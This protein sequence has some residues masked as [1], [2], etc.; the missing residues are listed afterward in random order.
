M[1]REELRRGSSERRALR[2]LVKSLTPGPRTH[3]HAKSNFLSVII[4]DM[5]QEYPNFYTDI[6]YTL[7][8]RKF[9]PLLKEILEIKAVRNK[10]LFG[11][12]YYMVEIESEEKRF[13]KELRAYIGEEYF[14]SIAVD[15]PK[16]FI[17]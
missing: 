14:Q 2:P 5:I 15:N 9:F 6:S 4:Q 11:S 13:G 10:V 12:D 16:K 17:G 8:K 1:A 7:N 3:G